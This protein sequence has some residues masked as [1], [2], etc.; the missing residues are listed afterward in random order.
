MVKK[1]FAKV[2]IQSF[3]NELKLPKGYNNKAFYLSL[4]TADM[5]DICNRNEVTR[6]MQDAYNMLNCARFNLV[7][8]QKDSYP[9]VLDEPHEKE[10]N[11]WIK[12]IYIDNALIAYNNTFDY[13]LQIVWFHYKI[14]EQYSQK[15]SSTTLDEILQGCM[16]KKIENKQNCIDSSL[17]TAMNS[18]YLNNKINDNANC[19]KHR[20]W[21]NFDS[22]DDGLTILDCNYDSIDTYKTENTTG[23]DNI[24]DI[25]KEHHKKVVNLMEILFNTIKT[26]I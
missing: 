10:P 24:I 16:W 8:A 3:F 18:F 6:R 17:F 19:L 5:T 15:L 21:I 26:S 13:I 9:E 25:L 11:L 20:R 1:F 23:K 22:V 14:Y 2:V 4:V 7:M 12:S